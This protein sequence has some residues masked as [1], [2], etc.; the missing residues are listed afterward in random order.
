M[1]RPV[2]VAAVGAML[3]TA[4]PAAAQAQAATP[5]T[6]ASYRAPTSRADSAKGPVEEGKTGLLTL[7]RESFAYVPD[8]RRDPFRSLMAI[9]DLRPMVAD[10]RLSAV[11]YD[12]S[13]NSLAVLE[14]L[15]T[16]EKY[17]VREGQQ[18]GRMRIAAIKPKQVVFT[19]EEFG[20][21]RQESL[22]L[23]DP[24]NPRTQQ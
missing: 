5:A 4:L 1:I 24:T 3:A 21:S 23:G 14:D 12:P 13:G 2:L 18:L 6:P 9:G 22:A 7:D 10:L 19:I 8:G 20:F 17:R 16:K 15:T 11:F